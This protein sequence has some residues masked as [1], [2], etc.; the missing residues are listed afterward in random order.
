M[1]TEVESDGGVS[2]PVRVPVS[3]EEGI[4]KAPGPVVA[5]RASK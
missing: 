4:E 1:A 2:G 5:I 3:T